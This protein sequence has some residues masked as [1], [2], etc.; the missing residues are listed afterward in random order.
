[1]TNEEMR[2]LDA[3][4]AEHVFGLELVQEK[5]LTPFTGLKERQFFVF[6]NGV[7][8]YGSPYYK[9][10]GYTTD[11]A[12][13]MLVLEKC[14]E[15]CGAMTNPCTIE[16]QHEPDFEEVPWAVSHDR[17]LMAGEAKTLPIA[18]AKFAKALFTTPNQEGK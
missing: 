18:I 2:E 16:I 17:T 10:L 4:I 8:Q 14:A 6:Q 12:D 11:P 9:K 5:D 1:M 7:Y 3:W 13:A 15:K